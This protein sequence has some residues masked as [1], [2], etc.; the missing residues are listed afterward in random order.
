MDPKKELHVLLA[1]ARYLEQK[2]KELCL[3]MTQLGARLR[4]IELDEFDEFLDFWVK[5][6]QVFIQYTIQRIKKKL[7]VDK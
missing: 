2:M 1:K 4:D 3:N 7:G 5:D 6:G